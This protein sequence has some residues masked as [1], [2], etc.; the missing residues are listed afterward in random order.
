MKDLN[1]KFKN[2]AGKSTHL[3]LRF[4]SQNLTKE[5]VQAAMQ[6]VIAAGLIVD[7]FGNPVH[8]KAVSAHYVETV[9]TPIFDEEPATPT[10]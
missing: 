2:T 1:L 4:V 5:V 9:S 7:K 3:K 6:E 10:V 8:V